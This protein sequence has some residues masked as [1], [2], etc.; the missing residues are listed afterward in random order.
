[1]VQYL[2]LTKKYTR[3]SQMAER[4]KDSDREWRGLGAPLDLRHTIQNFPNEPQKKLTVG[5]KLM[6]FW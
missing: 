1:L 6:D 4:Q 5:N 2:L 3:G